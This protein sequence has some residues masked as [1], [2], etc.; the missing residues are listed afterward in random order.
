MTRRVAFG[1]LAT[2]ALLVVATLDAPAKPSYGQKEKLDCTVCHVEKNS[3][4]LTDKG[5][6]YQALHTL[7]GYDRL[8]DNFGK[9]TFCHVDR[10]GSKKF[11][12]EGKKFRDVVK[13][14]S[15]VFEWLKAGH[16]GTSP[17]P[18]QAPTPAPA[19]RPE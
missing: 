16:T 14:M 19:P 4:K 2:A 15:G 8:L 12:K 13:D 11:T 1:A 7:D 18:S 6:Y 5:L 17:E 9:C 10:A 3:K